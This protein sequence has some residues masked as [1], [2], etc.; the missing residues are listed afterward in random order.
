MQE[1]KLC[2]RA[3]L[4][5]L[6]EIDANTAYLYRVANMRHG[7]NTIQSLTGPEGRIIVG[8]DIK[9]HIHEYF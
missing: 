8:N 4:K 7:V 5:W 3:R 1:I 6:K 2:Q 9:M